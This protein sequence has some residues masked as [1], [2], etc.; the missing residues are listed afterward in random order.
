MPESVFRNRAGEKQKPA[1]DKSEEQNVHKWEVTG[2][3][4]RQLGDCKEELSAD[5]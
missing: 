4:E 2:E 1:S 5:V 3:D